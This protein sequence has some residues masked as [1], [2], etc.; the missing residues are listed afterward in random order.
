MQFLFYKEVPTFCD[1]RI[2]D[3]RYLVIHLQAS[4]LWILCYFV[5]LNS[6]SAKKCF[7]EV[8]R[9]FLSSQILSCCLYHA[10]FFFVCCW[11]V[12]FGS[13]C[14]IDERELQ[15]QI[16]FWH[17]TITMLIDGVHISWN[18]S[19]SSSMDNSNCYLCHILS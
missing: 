11:M 12:F 14:T 16:N 8:W 19:T 4:T 2:R 15:L 13:K 9:L 5:I 3:P 6:K 10:S 1:F 18:C 7:S 17:I